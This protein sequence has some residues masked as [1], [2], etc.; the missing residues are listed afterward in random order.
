MLT[1]E[2]ID[3][4]DGGRRSCRRRPRFHT[5]SLPWRRMD[6]AGTNLCEI[7]RRYFS[8]NAESADFTLN[9]VFPHFCNWISGPQSFGKDWCSSFGILHDYYCL[10]RRSWNHSCVRN[11]PWK[12]R[13][14]EDGE[15]EQAEGCY[16]CRH[17]DGFSQ[18][19]CQYAFSLVSIIQA[20]VRFT[21]DILGSLQTIGTG[22]WSRL[23]NKDSSM[24]CL[25]ASIRITSDH[26]GSD[27]WRRIVNFNRRRWLVHRLKAL[28]IFLKTW[29]KRLLD[30]YGAKMN[31]YQ[32]NN[33]NCYL[34][35]FSFHTLYAK[36]RFK[37]HKS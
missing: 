32:P 6:T 20:N 9:R 8:A 13:W 28:I 12:S 15:H 31:T 27:E 16:N 30:Q 22:Y 29:M 10:R 18:V 14:R 4:A 11:S 23:Q 37:K 35:F 1:H 3:D 33:Y 2:F 34:L 5:P 26:C 36:M 7:F 17:L 24:Q 21:R 19:R 25:E